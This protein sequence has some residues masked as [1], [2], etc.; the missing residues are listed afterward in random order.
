MFMLLCAHGYSGGLS[1]WFGLPCFQFVGFSETKSTAFCTW[2]KSN[3]NSFSTCSIKDEAFYFFFSWRRGW[4]TG[5]EQSLFSF[6]R[7]RCFFLSCSRGLLFHIY[8]PLFFWAA[9]SRCISLFI[10]AGF[11]MAWSQVDLWF[12]CLSSRF[13]EVPFLF[14]GC[15]VN[16]IERSWKFGGGEDGYEWLSFFNIY[17]FF[18]IYRII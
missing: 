18:S 2:P 14:L 11:G 5:F 3:V 8:L 10:W 17:S 4:T 12:S 16:I 7:T 13:F 1:S 6:L 15:V 9:W